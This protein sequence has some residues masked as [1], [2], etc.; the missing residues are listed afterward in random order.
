MQRVFRIEARDIKWGENPTDELVAIITGIEL[1]AGEA[2]INPGFAEGSTVRY[3]LAKEVTITDG[4]ITV[5]NAA[6]G[7]TDTV[8]AL[9]FAD[10]IHE[11]H[12]KGS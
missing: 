7:D 1:V 5:S 8:S 3:L 10:C 12:A 9:V 6:I 11:Q 4:V 2:E